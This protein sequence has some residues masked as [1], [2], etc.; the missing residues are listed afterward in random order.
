MLSALTR[1]WIGSAIFLL[2]VVFSVELDLPERFL[3]N[4]Q[5]PLRV[6]CGWI[7]NPTP[8]NV[9]L[10][11]RDAEWTIGIQ[12]G[13]QAEGDLPDFQDKQFVKTNGSYGYGCGCIKGRFNSK[14]HRVED[15]SAATQKPLVTCR[16]DPSLRK[17]EP[18]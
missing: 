6:R 10:T 7:S 12:G 1:D 5:T 16:H 18:K 2:L 17:K 3:V 11:D 15:I 9:W 4:A 8:A 14:T 13:Y